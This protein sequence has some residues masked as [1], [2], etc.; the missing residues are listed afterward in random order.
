[1]TD[2]W[3]VVGIVIN[4]VYK[5][6]VSVEKGARNRLGAAVL[7]EVVG[8]GSEASAYGKDDELAKKL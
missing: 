5:F 4:L 8:V 6:A 1:M 3:F 7:E 2:L